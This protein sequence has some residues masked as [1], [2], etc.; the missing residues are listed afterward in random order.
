VPAQAEARA[1]KE[2]ARL[3]KKFCLLTPESLDLLLQLQ[4]LDG[5]LVVPVGQAL[6]RERDQAL[7][8]HQK[9]EAARV[10]RAIK[11]RQLAEHLGYPASDALVV[12]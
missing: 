3:T 6:A 7:A 4:R 1:E 12:N 2:Q 11:A 9:A 8:N 10:S 5:E